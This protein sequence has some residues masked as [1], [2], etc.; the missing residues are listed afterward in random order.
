MRIVFNSFKASTG[1]NRA[2]PRKRVKKMPSVP[3]KMPMS[4][5]VGWN[6]PQLDGS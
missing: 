3:M 5:A 1:K 2:K 6:S 4:K